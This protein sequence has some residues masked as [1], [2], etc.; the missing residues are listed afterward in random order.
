MMYSAAAISDSY[1]ISI[2]KSD[3]ETMIDNQKRRM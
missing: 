3:I 2:K 1:L